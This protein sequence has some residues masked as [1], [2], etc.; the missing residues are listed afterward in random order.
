M[1]D[2]HLEFGVMPEY[3]KEGYDVA[4]LAG[5]IGK[6]GK[7]LDD[8]LESFSVPVVYV[9][10]NH[11]YYGSDIIDTIG[12]NNGSITIEGVKF[13]CSTFWSKPSFSSF[14]NI[15]DM[16]QIKYYGN[17]FGTN[18]IAAEH[19]LAEEYLA[20][21][22]DADVVVTHFPPTRQAQHPMYKNSPL[23]DYFLNNHEWLVSLMKPKLWIAGHTH[24]DFDYMVGDTRVVS[25]QCGYPFEN[26]GY[27][28]L[29]IEV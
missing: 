18:E 11:E 20:S 8:F 24:G 21:V 14:R 7:Q 17:Q 29:I 25:S 5:D 12:L 9:P 26:K 23:T 13:A 4:V 2:L 1:S 28:P 19:E 15:N 10:G 3:P 6:P 16:F 22:T 27:T